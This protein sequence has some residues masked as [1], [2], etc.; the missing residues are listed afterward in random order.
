[1]VRENSRLPDF[2]SVLNGED[3][4]FSGSHGIWAQ[5]TS[6]AFTQF[7]LHETSKPLDAI[8]RA[9]L[10]WEATGSMVFVVDKKDNLEIPYDD[11]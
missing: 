6:G 8:S 2:Y 7:D 10:S 9:A 11:V 1:M 3:I 4:A 5:H